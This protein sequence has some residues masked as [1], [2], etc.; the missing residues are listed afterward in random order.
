MWIL[1][2]KGIITIQWLANCTI[3]WIEICRV[4]SIIH[5]L[6]NWALKVIGSTPVGV[7]RFFLQDNCVTDFK[8]LPS[9]REQKGGTN[10]AQN[11]IRKTA[12]RIEITQHF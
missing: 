5:F 10:T 2:L 7:L 8:T 12:N 9:E 1:G 3:Q 6:N 4:D 11:I